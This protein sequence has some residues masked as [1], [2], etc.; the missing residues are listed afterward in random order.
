MDDR[1]GL[2]TIRTELD[3]G[4]LRATL[5]RPERMNAINDVM[6]KELCELFARIA[7]DSTEVE[8]VVLTGAGRGFCAGGDFKQMAENNEAGYDDGFSQL[9]IDSVA[10]ARNILAIRQPV[11]A[12]VNG[13]AIG[14]GATLALFCDITYICETARIGDPHVQAGLVAADG[15]VVLWPMLLG[16]ARAKEYLFTGDLLTGREAERIGLVNHALPAEEVLPAAEAM[17][18]RLANG[19]ALAIRFNKRLVNKE[20]EERVDRIYEMALAMEAVTFRSAD[21]LE[22]VKAFAERRPPVFRRGQR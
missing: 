21:H 15:G 2:T 20:L 8:V 11:I 9:M 22:A 17:A 13:D 4:V 16:P 1:Y 18:R 5:N 12:A 6:H 14:L 7:A 10:M 3:G 19:A